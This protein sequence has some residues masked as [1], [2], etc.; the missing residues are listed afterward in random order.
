MELLDLA[1]NSNNQSERLIP[2]RPLGIPPGSALR[3]L[4]QR[5]QALT[6]VFSHC[7][8]CAPEKQK[9]EGPARLLSMCYAAVLDHMVKQYLRSPSSLQNR[10]RACLS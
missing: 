4:T 8:R 7:I 3:L 2:D 6:S 9:L 10:Q 1:I 5:G